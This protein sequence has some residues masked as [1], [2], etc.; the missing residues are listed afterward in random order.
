MNPPP[1]PSEAPPRMTSVLRKLFLTLFLRGRGA[2][3]LNKA[4]APKSVGQ[5][6]LLT[7]LVYAL[8]GCMALGFLHSPVFVFA[9]Y[10][11]AMTFFF[12]GLF[13]ASSAGEILF[14]K[15]EADILLHRPVTPEAMLWAKVRVLIEVSLWLAGAFNFPGLLVAA[16]TGRW[17][18]SVVH[19]FS[20]GLEAMFC[21]GCVVLGY[22]LCLRWFG[23]ERLEGLMTMVQVLLAISA[24]LAG[25]IL[26]RVIIPLTGALKLEDSPWWLFLIPPAWF[27]GIDDALAGSAAGSSWLS[28]VL[29]LGVTALVLW[30]A[31]GRLAKHYEAGLQM[32]GETAGPKIAR[33]GRRRWLDALVSAPPLCWWLSNPVSRSSFLLTLA[34]LV[35]DRDVKLRVYPGIVP[36]LI[37]PFVFLFQNGRH[38]A[39]TGAAFGISFSGAYMG[40]IAL[41][42]I[43]FLQYSQHWLAADVF[44]YAPLVG[45]AELGHG[46]R[47]AVLLVLALPMVVLMAA[48]VWL[49]HGASGQMLLLLPG[50]ILL[51]V[52][53]LVPG[54]GGIA[55]LSRPPDAAKSAGRGAHMI[56]ALIVSMLVAGLAMGSWDAGFFWPFIGAEAAVAAGFYFFFKL[57]IRRMRWPALD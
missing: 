37:V 1:I 33:G 42:G 24:V 40:L 11:H 8:V 19:I 51:P 38:H 36:M 34:Y 53:A 32:L 46:V 9:A 49:L 12:L 15:E 16:L 55:P 35:R 41:W 39:G 31:F 57:R 17:E 47:R 45:P 48:I 6:L 7:L 18:F 30:L 43:Q 25:Q 3:G 21:A 23:R 50:M 52:F 54:L 4:G 56:V 5:K 44:R 13:I 2:R 14:N 20:T 29:A 10:L 27:A 26:P 22:Q 28:A